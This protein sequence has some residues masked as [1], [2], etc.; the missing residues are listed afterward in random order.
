MDGFRGFILVHA[1]LC[2]GLSP[3]EWDES[4]RPVLYGT[5]AQAELWLFDAAEMRSEAL[6]DAQM[7][8]KNDDRWVE[9]AML[10]AEGGLTLV[11]QGKTFTPDV[12]LDL[13]S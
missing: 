13:I 4:N 1:T 12:L 11:D 5:R 9:A 6:L 8:S 10:D 7:E 3:A 2:G